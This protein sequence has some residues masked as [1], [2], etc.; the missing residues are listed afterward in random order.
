MMKTVTGE[1]VQWRQS[2]MEKKNN[3]GMG[4]KIGYGI[5]D[6]GGNLV[7]AAA[8]AF[9]TMYYTDSVLLS[10]AFIGTMM[11]FTRLLDGISDIIMGIIIDKTYTKYGKARPWVLFSAFPLILS[12]ILML[13]V[14]LAQ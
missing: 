10:A 4:K 9:V 13:N 11:L 6:L 12:F 2:S 3:F 8:G 5:G 1:H 7:S 14:P